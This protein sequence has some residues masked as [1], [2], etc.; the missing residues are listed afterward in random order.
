MLSICTV[1]LSSLRTW[2]GG[3]AGWV[4]PTLSEG[5][6]AWVCR[7]HGLEKGYYADGEDAYDMRKPLSREV[8]G[9]PPLEGSSDAAAAGAG[10]GAGAGASTGTG[11]AA[12]STASAPGGEP[13]VPPADKATGSGGAA[14]PSVP[15]S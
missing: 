14:P 12:P 7:I 6:H 11:D 13:P 3:A 5:K 15:P 4:L 2:R 9:L 1:I 8:V 10:A